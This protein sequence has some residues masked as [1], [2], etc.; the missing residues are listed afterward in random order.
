MNRRTLLKSLTAASTLAILPVTGCA[1]SVTGMLSTIISALEGVLNYAA[2]NAAWLPQVQQVLAKL[3]AEL[4]Q[5]QAGQGV[6]ATLE[7]VL[8]DALPVLALIPLTAPFAPLIALIVAGI[9]AIVNYFAPKPAATKFA[10]NPYNGLVVLRHPHV[11]QTYQG[12][13]RAQFNDAANGLG[14]TKAVIK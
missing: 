1:F 6:W 11:L 2:A 4:G 10:E 7:E 9:E 12:A 3:Q 14:L 8:N 13:F 5:W